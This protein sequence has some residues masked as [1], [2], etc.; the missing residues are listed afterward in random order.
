MFRLEFDR[1]DNVYNY[2]P[3][4]VECD[5]N[6]GGCSQT[7]NNNEGSFEC[8]CRNGYV[9]DNDGQNCSGIYI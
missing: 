6:N 9:L 5:Y 7:C 3:D 2:Q 8:L 4:I 1:Y